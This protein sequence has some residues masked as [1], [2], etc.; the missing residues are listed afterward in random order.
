MSDN[1]ILLDKID[2]IYKIMDNEEEL[3]T[4]VILELT[5]LIQCS[6]LTSLPDTSKHKLL[7]LFKKNLQTTNTELQKNMLALLCYCFDLNLF[8]QELLVSEI[9]LIIIDGAFKKK[10]ENLEDQELW[11]KA[12][13]AL[14]KLADTELTPLIIK[15]SLDILEAI[16]LALTSKVINSPKKLK[17]RSIPTEPYNLLNE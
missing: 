7:I 10:V 12:L 9:L 16:K 8:D 6:N 17:V 15:H 2:D 1:N 5:H 3:K 14:L 4:E 13:D 11:L